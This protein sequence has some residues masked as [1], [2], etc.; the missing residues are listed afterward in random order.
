M[1]NKK[2]FAILTLV[3]FMMTLMPVAAF[4]DDP[5]NAKV[6]DAVKPA[7]VKTVAVEDDNNSATISF[8]NSDTLNFYKATSNE[9]GTYSTTGS[10]IV[11]DITS[12]VAGDYVAFDKELTVPEL[13]GIPASKVLNV[14]S[15][16][17]DK[18]LIIANLANSAAVYH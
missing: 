6:A 7:L 16:D 14:T 11:A 9:N 10:A 17:V 2:L 3:C 8:A 18:N 4:A 13:T 12:I 5:V 1:K 15:D